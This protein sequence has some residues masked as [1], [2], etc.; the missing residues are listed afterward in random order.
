MHKY[1]GQDNYKAG[2]LLKI[3]TAILNTDQL[4]AP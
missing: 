1:K 2:Q 3:V 4:V